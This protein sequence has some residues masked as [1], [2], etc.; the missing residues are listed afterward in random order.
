MK[1][2][3]FL[4]LTVF[5]C[6]S[7]SLQKNDDLYVIIGDFYYKEKEI[8]IN[9]KQRIYNKDLVVIKHALGRNVSVEGVYFISLS[10][11]HTTTNLLITSN[12]K[13]Y[14]LKADNHIEEKLNSLLKKVN[15]SKINDIVKQD[16]FK[17]DLLQIVNNNNFMKSRRTLKPL[18]VK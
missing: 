5:F 12:K 18:N 13:Y 1:N 16:S 4:F 17:R 7:C 2:I 9:H 8:T 15:D 14:V 6:I 3:L 10:I 11:T